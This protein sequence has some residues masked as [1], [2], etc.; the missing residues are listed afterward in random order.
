MTNILHEIFEAIE[1]ADLMGLAFLCVIVVSLWRLH[2]DANSS[3]N[4]FDLVMEGGKLGK[5]A[6]AFWVGIG[7]LSWLMIKL[8][9]S[10]QMTEGYA[11][12]YVGAV[13]TP[14]VVKMFAAPTEPTQEAPK[15]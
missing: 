1:F 4:L 10:G 8:Q 14:V 2:H 15:P 5:L 3:I 11:A 13:V 6:T 9:Q 12:I 7:V